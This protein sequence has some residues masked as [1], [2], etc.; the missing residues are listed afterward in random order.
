[1]PARW[2]GR[3]RRGPATRRR[4]AGAASHRGSP[5]RRCARAAAD[6]AARVRSGPAQVELPDR[7]AVVGPAGERAAL[8]QLPLVH[9]AV[10]DVAAAQ[11]ERPLEIERRR[12]RPTDDRVAHVRRE[13]AQP[14]DDEVGEPLAR[15]VPAAARE[16]PRYAAR[17]SWPCAFPGGASDES[18]ADGIV[19][20]R[21]GSVGSSPRSCAACALRYPSRSAPSNEN[22]RCTSAGPEPSCGRA[23][24]RGSS[25]SARWTRP[26][27]PLMSSSRSRAATGASRCSGP[28]RSSIVR[29]GSAFETTTSALMVVHRRARR[30][31]RACRRVGPRPR[32]DP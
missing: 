14:P 17:R 20:S 13:L 25:P 18:E 9:R 15:I 4:P 19:S 10:E 8:E 32:G 16:L 1:M 11:P 26:I 6:G 21:T 7:R 23:A 31:P 30:R 22:A 12:D 5:G 2:S 28:T 3:P 24:K 29:R 27:E